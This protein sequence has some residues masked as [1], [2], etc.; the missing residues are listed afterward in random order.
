MF[1]EK[2]LVRGSDIFEYHPKML[3]ESKSEDLNSEI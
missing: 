1:E 3:S 2:C